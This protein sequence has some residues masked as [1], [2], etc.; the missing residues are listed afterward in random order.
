M[1]SLRTVNAWGL[2]AAIVLSTASASW[3]ANFAGG[4]GEPNDP[5]QIAT[6]EQL[7][8][9]GSD[10]NLLVKH[11]VLVA[12]IDLDPNLPGGRVFTQAVIAA[13][14]NWTQRGD[15]RYVQYAAFEG[16]FDGA[17]HIV[18]NLAIDDIQV[19]DG[20]LT[21]SVGLFGTVGQRGRVENL[22]LQGISVKGL[23]P[24]GGLAGTNEGTILRCHVVGQVAGSGDVG[25]LAGGNTGVIALC[26]TSGVVS[27]GEGGG[28][29]GGLVGGNLWGIVANCYSDAAVRAGHG[30]SVGG[31]IGEHSG[32]LWNCYATGSVSAGD[33]SGFVGGLVGYEQGSVVNCCA[34]GSV[35][36]GDKSECV[37]GL[38]GWNSSSYGGHIANCYAT[39]HIS[40]GAG[41]KYVSGLL[42]DAGSAG[43]IRHCFWDVETSGMSSSAGGTGL[44]TSEMQRIQTY[45][46]AGW[47]WVDERANGTADLWLIPKTGG[48]PKLAV[49]SDQ[50][51]TQMLKGSGTRDD[52]Y[53]I[54]TVEDIGAMS[55]Y[56]PS[57]CYKLEADIDMSG[58]VW[59]I[60]PIAGFDGNFDGAGYAVSN[61][62]IRGGGYLGLFGLVN[63]RA[64]V[65]DV[66][67]RDANIVGAD[68]GWYLGVLVGHN[69]GSITRCHAAGT[70]TGWQGVGGL[71]GVNGGNIAACFA[72]TSIFGAGKVQ[73]LGGFVGHNDIRGHIT[74]CYARGNVSGG[75]GCQRLG[76]FVGDNSSSITN[77]YASGDVS[78]VP[79]SRDLGGFVGSNRMD[80]RLGLGVNGCYWLRPAENI[81]L[82]NNLGFGLWGEDMKRHSSFVGWDFDGV[83]MICEGKDY[84][85]LQ[86]ERVQCQ[87]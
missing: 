71:A 7:L 45:L 15:I 13:D 12:D 72:T 40:A 75:E 68:P 25:G 67:I 41:S 80:F 48:Y 85:R 16:T 28:T 60:A 21:R 24:V 10:R 18:H 77:C 50:A 26:H 4:I 47:D 63:R 52:P 61:L 30:H 43:D 74:D 37:G 79:G 42:G 5:Y 11:F 76:G 33:G 78:G 23:Y 32:S 20:S 39:G 65:V 53:R 57:A 27:G 36:A 66:A 70:I 69:T 83:W 59:T 46:A 44:T 6:A 64:E 3:A 49:F 86:W 84:P 14:V 55:R 8:S 29:L 51:Q 38:I 54:A 2:F 19:V 17:G 31:L 56:D 22:N 1:A 87:P 35:L 82:T 9:I 81:V 58:V 62:T 34:A 73:G